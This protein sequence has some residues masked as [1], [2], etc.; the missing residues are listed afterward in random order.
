MP[1]K[2]SLQ[3]QGKCIADNLQWHEI[4]LLLLEEY[5]YYGFVSMVWNGH[6]TH[7]IIPNHMWRA[8]PFVFVLRQS[9]GQV[10]T[11]CLENRLLGWTLE[12]ARTWNVIGGWEGS[13]LYPKQWH[14]DMAWHCCNWKPMSSNTKA[15]SC[16]R[17]FP[18]FT[19]YTMGKF[20]QSSTGAN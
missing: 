20:G 6:Y 3:S 2:T 10:L 4:C 9:R 7:H 13:T 5:G 1:L 11:N 14:G 19:G 15:S 8:L 18:T 12:F 16:V 17:S